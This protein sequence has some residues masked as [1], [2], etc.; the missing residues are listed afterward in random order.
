[1]DHQDSLLQDVQYLAEKRRMEWRSRLILIICL[2]II[3][4]IVV[5]FV[6]AVT[7]PIAI[8]NQQQPNISESIK[9]MLSNHC[10]FGVAILGA[11]GGMIESD[12]TSVLLRT[13]TSEGNFISL[14]AGTMMSGLI[15]FTMN[16]KLNLTFFKALFPGLPGWLADVDLAELSKNPE[17]KRQYYMSL[18]GYIMKQYILGYFIG[19]SHLDH[20]AGLAIS[21]PEGSY[22]NANYPILPKSK[23]IVASQE[24]ANVLNSSVF[25]NVIWPN[26]PQLTNWYQY[27]TINFGNKYYVSDLLYMTNNKFDKNS[28]DIRQLPSP[29]SY[30]FSDTT[31][32]IFPLCHEVTSSAFL[33]ETANVQLVYF[34]DT[35]PNTGT[36][37]D[38]R[39]KVTDV[40]NSVDITKLAAIL[41]EVSFS[42]DVP[43]S[44]LYGHLRPKDLI[45]LLLELK[46]LK[47]NPSLSTLKVVITH[48][49]PTFT[50]IFSESNRAII[51]RQLNQEAKQVQLDCNFTFPNQGDFICVEK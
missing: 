46:S 42:N 35:G 36:S 13:N 6:L 50:T 31:V 38:W 25:N 8:N 45:Q 18:S 27:Q 21:S 39:S 20:V 34:S 4:C 11:E 49:K 9:D 15:K 28:N 2:F 26:I 17:D 47:G 22:F 16:E 14:D 1:M 24:V 51:T 10:T 40:W 5:G 48:I 32:K 33:F 23:S 3:F 12:L 44:S 41:I 19:H 43:D 7:I 37:C 29:G 30:H